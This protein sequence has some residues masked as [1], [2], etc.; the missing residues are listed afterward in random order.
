M[1]AQL[2][3]ELGELSSAPPSNTIRASLSALIYAWAS[4]A[5]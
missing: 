1:T 3:A 4:L 2:N 5:A